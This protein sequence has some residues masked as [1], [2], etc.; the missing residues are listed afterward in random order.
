M[1]KSSP[2]R[3][4]QSQLTKIFALQNKKSISELK[5]IWHNH[6][7]SASIRLSMTGYQFVT[8]ELKLETYSFE[9]PR[10]LTNKNLIQLE[11]LF[12]GPYYYWSRTAKFIVLDEQDAS[13]LQLLGGDLASYLDSL[14]NSN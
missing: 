7:D 6:T 2:K 12:P 8:K 9:L 13:W 10:P 1:I 3:Y 11:R 4:T 14:E 5:F